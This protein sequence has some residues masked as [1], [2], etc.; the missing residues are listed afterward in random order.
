MAA[1]LALAAGGAAFGADA[2]AGATAG[3]AAGAIAAAK[4]ARCSDGTMTAMSQCLE[5][6]R[7]E[8]DTRLNVVYRALGQALAEPARLKDAQR[9]WIAFRDLEC[10]FRRLNEGGS[11][12]GFSANACLVDLTEKRI[13]EL[14]A[15]Q[16]C[17]GC[18]AFKPAFA[19]KGAYRLPP[20]AGVAGQPR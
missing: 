14:E 8:S 16:P 19:G 17:E 18:I 4:V 5:R 2:G 10:R 15:V 1:V 9:A 20:R 3:T 12:Q 11:L 6:E 7:Q 13:A